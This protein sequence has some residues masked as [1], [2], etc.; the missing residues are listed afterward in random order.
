MAN[1]SDFLSLKLP[2]F[3]EYRDSWWEPV[4]ENFTKIDTWSQSLDQEVTD[5]RFQAATLSKFLEVAH[6]PDG[7]LIAT[8]EVISA[9]NSPVYGFQNPALAPDPATR[10]QLGERLDNVDWEIWRA[11]EGQASLKAMSAFRQNPKNAILSGL[12]FGTGNNLPAWMGATGA[13][14]QVDGS[15][16]PLWF[17]IDGKLGRVRTLKQVTLTGAAGIKYIYAQYLP[18]GDAGKIIVDGDATVAPPSSPAGTTAL[19][20][21]NN[22]VYFY[23]LTTSPF[24]SSGVWADDLV[25]LIDSH[26][27]GEYI[28]KSIESSSQLLI[29]GV[30]PVGGLSAINYSVS[31]PLAVSLGFVT[32]ETTLTSDQICIGEAYF[33]GTNL[34]DFPGE[35]GIKIKP[36]HFLDTFVSDWVEIDTTAGTPNLGTATPGKYETKI[37]HNLGSD[38]LSITIQVSQAD[39]G[40]GTIEELTLASL[41]SNQDVDVASTMAL[42]KTSDPVFVAPS[43]AADTFVPN[44]SGASFVQGDFV[45]GSLSGSTV[46]ALGGGVTGSLTGSVD[47]AGAVRCK[48]NRN[49]IWIKNSTLD[50][51]YTDYD[52]NDNTGG[53]LRVIVRKRG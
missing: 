47:L 51:F 46:Y 11:R 49:S 27:K 8:F 3:M 37:N 32:D 15:S 36:R 21:D 25:N 20:V 19:D 5:A 1:Y 12:G 31:D 39:D 22:P 18:D 50:R 6:N 40:T 14:V 13:N 52:D 38:K 4:N 9:E 2:G 10:Y 28:V 41:I 53:F 33:N 23:D 17:S 30:F 45:P 34:A 29:I 48:W 7:T 26:D 24:V 44:G 35:A 42:S 43:H 16:T